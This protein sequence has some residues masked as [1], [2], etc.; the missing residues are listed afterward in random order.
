MTHWNKYGSSL[1]VNTQQNIDACE[2]FLGTLSGNEDGEALWE[3][4]EDGEIT[5]I[6]YPTE[7]LQNYLKGYLNINRWLKKRHLNSESGYAFTYVNEEDPDDRSVGGINSND[8][9]ISFCQ[10][11]GDGEITHESF[12]I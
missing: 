2:E 10:I 5:P 1:I 9:G 8:E 3:I 4:N 6:S 7:R 11:N 12:K